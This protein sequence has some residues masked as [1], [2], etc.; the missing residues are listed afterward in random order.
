MLHVGDLKAPYTYPN[1][2]HL[3]IT[4]HAIVL[5]PLATDITC[6][7]YRIHSPYRQVFRIHS[8]LKRFVIFYSFWVWKYLVAELRI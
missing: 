3:W 8:E 5:Q 1:S 4:F 6:K 7:V 2:L